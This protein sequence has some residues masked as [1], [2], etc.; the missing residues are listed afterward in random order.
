MNDRSSAAL[1]EAI[2]ATYSRPTRQ[3]LRVIERHGP[4]VTQAQIETA[5]RSYTRATVT[6]AALHALIDGMRVV[7][8]TLW[9]IA[10]IAAVA[11]G[12]A[13]GFLHQAQVKAWLGDPPAKQTQAQA[14]KR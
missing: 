2:D 4:A 11:A 8:G 10:T 3:A 13:W 9:K 7:M 12:I 5:G 14:P 1:Q 6:I